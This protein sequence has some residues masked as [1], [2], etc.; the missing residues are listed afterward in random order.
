M[1]DY[2]NIPSM[3]D[4]DARALYYTLPPDPK[5]CAADADENNDTFILGYRKD[6]GAAEILRL[7][8]TPSVVQQRSLSRD[9]CFDYP[10]ASRETAS[11]WI[12]EDMAFTT[13]Q[14]SN[15]GAAAHGFDLLKVLYPCKE[16]IAQVSSMMTIWESEE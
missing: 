2:T 12:E 10:N 9:F 6:S 13:I 3:W 5:Y 11:E 1:Y 15:P 8:Q 7:R 4:C 16:A 14:T